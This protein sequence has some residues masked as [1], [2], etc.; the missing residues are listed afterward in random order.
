MR[1]R[2]GMQIG[3][4]A[5]D[6]LEALSRNLGVPPNMGDIGRR[7]PF[8]YLFPDL[9]DYGCDNF[10][11]DD[12][13]VA[14]ALRQ[15]GE[16]MTEG[17][18]GIAGPADH[19]EAEGIPAAYTYFGQFVDHDITFTKSG[20]PD[21]ANPGRPADPR[22]LIE[23]SRTASMDLDSL[24]DNAPRD[25]EKF[26]LGVVAKE[27]VPRAD[28][29][30]TDDLHDLPRRPPSAVEA[31][32]REA[33]IG[34]PRN[35]E[36]LIV[37]QLHVAF[38][39]AHNAIVDQ[40]AT[41][42][43]ARQKLS[44]HYQW[45]VLHDYLKRVAD[46]VT[47]DKVL[48]TGPKHFH[49][50]PVRPG[51]P[52]EFAG[53]AY[54]FGHSMVRAAYN[55]NNIFNEG[56]PFS[57]LFTFTALSGQI[58]GGPAP[59]FPTLPQNWI[60]DWRRFLPGLGGSGM[61]NMARPIDPLLVDPLAHLTNVT[62]IEEAPPNNFL[63]QRNLL[64]GWQIRLPV[65]QAVAAALEIPKLTEAEVLSLS[66]GV[67]E[68]QRDVLVAN[69]F[70]E[71]TPLWYYILLEAQQVRQDTG[72]SRLGPVG[73]TILAEVFV[74]LCRVSLNSILRECHFK[75]SLGR[76]PGRFDLQDLLSLAKVI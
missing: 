2:H 28:V 37:A 59:Q 64:R 76:Q 18:G 39:R 43:E 20:L 10:L 8:V 72:A 14:S 73:S 30:S 71:R 63:A 9:H 27:G 16:T 1:Y 57:L 70:A 13:G 44:Q 25:G 6:A 34:D 62:G 46:P 49:P 24:Y 75:P 32:D 58:G 66:Q 26:V 50:D 22:P 23:N 47:V 35:D 48:S 53:A 52:L 33:L 65:G 21:L 3:K 19:N 74:G 15:L 60:I 38:L 41:G 36:N 69:G 61:V 54:R 29:V 42:S 12:A 7:N 31:E 45:M 40:G 56:T 51:M 4:G 17:V 68:R 11:P 5:A 55:H 67:S